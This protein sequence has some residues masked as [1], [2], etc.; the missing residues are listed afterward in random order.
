MATPHEPGTCRER[1]RGALREFGEVLEGRRDASGGGRLWGSYGAG[2]LFTAP[3]A[4]AVEVEAAESGGSRVRVRVIGEE[5]SPAE[6]ETGAQAGERTT[7]TKLEELAAELCAEIAS[8]RPVGRVSTIVRIAERVG[9]DLPALGFELH[10]DERWRDLEIVFLMA[11]SL[12]I[13]AAVTILVVNSEYGD[14]TESISPV[15]GPLGLGLF[16]S[17]ALIRIGRSFSAGRPASL[18]TTV[19]RQRLSADRGLR[20]RM[21]ATLVLGVGIPVGAVV[22]FMMLVP[23][24]W[25]YIAFGLL[26]AAGGSAAERSSRRRKRGPR[27][28][29]GDVTV[30]VARLCM[31]ADMTVPQAVTER[32]PVPTAWTSDGRLHVTESLLDLLE[33]PEVEAVLAH[34]LAHLAHR[35]AGVM[36]LATAPS[37]LLL[38]LVAICVNPGRLAYS[39]D[40]REKAGWVLLAVVCVPPA[41]VLGWSSRLLG[42]GLSRAREYAADASAVTLTG[43]P[44]ALASALLKLHG[45]GQQVPRADLREAEADSAL[46]IVDVR[47]SRLGQL[48][49][50]HPP[51]DERVARLERMEERLQA[52]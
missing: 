16:V 20:V 37:R 17:K 52:R 51:I 32:G 9:F 50:T 22:T 24:G 36:E 23:H 14:G 33:P 29:E 6:E 11:G 19:G 4:I 41:F 45:A 30:M 31:R 34:E 38:A 2:L 5:T 35:D 10:R 42:L 3:A 40:L 8:E 18:P 27:A 47:A 25:M 44:S 28:P 43:R 48:L 1:A 49:R 7:E 46:C 39:F 26:L 21:V 12:A 15:L 13:F